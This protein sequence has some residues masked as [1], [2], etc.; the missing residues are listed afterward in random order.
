M[1]ITVYMLLS[2]LVAAFV[3]V[4]SF[5]VPKY[6]TNAINNQPTHIT[7]SSLLVGSDV[8]NLLYQE[9]E[10]L[11][12]KRGELEETL[13]TNAKPLEATT[14]KVRGVGKSGGFGKSSGGSSSK[15][16]SKAEGKAYAKILKKEGVLRIDNVLT[17]DTAD[18][19]RELL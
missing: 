10:K 8:S 2:V 9:Q 5:F 13:V 14:I 16:S 3:P 4:R 7:S 18:A 15:A 1:I 6:D 12:V 11:I 17:P 19:V